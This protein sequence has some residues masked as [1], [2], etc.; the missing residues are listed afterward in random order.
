M[1]KEL[2]EALL[3]NLQ[4]HA[5]IALGRFYTISNEET[6][7][8][9]ESHEIEIKENFNLKRSIAKCRF[10]KDTNKCTIYCNLKTLIN[11]SDNVRY[12][13]MSHEIAHAIEFILYKYSSH[14]DRWQFIHKSIGGNALEEIHIS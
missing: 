13:T 14:G 1:L 2:K 12:E 9:L 11:T 3:D 7:K 10:N 4:D 8:L 6:T 5:S